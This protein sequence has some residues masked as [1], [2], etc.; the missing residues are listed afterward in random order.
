M[1]NTVAK[2]G[3]TG[4]LVVANAACVLAQSI[5][6]SGD[7]AFG[8]VPLGTTA[9]GS[10]VISNTGGASI[11]GS[12][13]IG[14][15]GCQASGA[16]GPGI[17]TTVSL[18]PGSV[19]GAQSGSY[20]GVILLTPVTMNS[21]TFTGT[22]SG[23]S[24]S[25]PV[26][27]LWTFTS[28]GNTYSFNASSLIYAT[29]TLDSMNF[30]CAGTLTISGPTVNL[31]APGVFSELDWA[32]NP[33]LV[34]FDYY[35]AL[36]VTPVPGE[37]AVSSVNYPA[38]FAGNDWT[39]TIGPNGSVQ[40]PVIFTPTN[41]E[42]YGGSITV[43]SDASPNINTIAVSGTGFI[44]SG[45]LT[46]VDANPL[47]L[48]SIQLPASIDPTTLA[49]AAAASPTRF[50][51]AADGIT[52]LLL[53]FTNSVPGTVVFSQSGAPDGILTAIDGSPLPDSGVPT[54]TAGCQQIAFA[55]YTVPDTITPGQM[56]VNFS[57]SF[58]PQDCA[59]SA[60]PTPWN[61]N[62]I[63]TPVVLIHGLWGSIK[64]WQAMKTVLD[65]AKIQSLNVDYS[66]MLNAAGPFAAY[67]NVVNQNIRTL[68]SSLRNTGIAVTKADV[69]AHSMGGI[70]TRMDANDPNSYRPDNFGAGYIRRVV[71][72][73]TPHWGS[74]AA[75]VLLLLAQDAP[76]FNGQLST[77]G[78]PV[79]LGAVQD[80]DPYSFGESLGGIQS[81]WLGP[82]KLPSFAISGSVSQDGDFG[83]RLKSLYSESGASPSPI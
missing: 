17:S 63:Q 74:C 65:N 2:L 50:T 20:S 27:P 41:I 1:V 49:A 71:T 43:T 26:T 22:G 36:P 8:N 37:L 7:L 12:V 54:E 57:A 78:V 75:P 81:M 3:F 21:F 61:L 55:L 10:L 76:S 68:I 18:F 16:S 52:K 62:L 42:Q 24:L 67:H 46:L 56:N 77:F 48:S 59:V 11:N 82:L 33:N 4:L 25:S 38:G 31:S 23:A 15:N 47:F 60:S 6:L 44:V 34:P 70:L 13:A 64:T 73:D 53:E 66:S 28:G 79:N 40:I 19:Q 30:S 29:V 83:W 58:T 72:V 45:G 39:G 69:V 5:S 14:G 9:Q 51:A 35:D 80:L 32:I